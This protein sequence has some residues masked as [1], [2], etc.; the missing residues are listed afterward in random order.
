[1]ITYLVITLTGGIRALLCRYFRTGNVWLLIRGLIQLSVFKLLLFRIFLENET[2]GVSIFC[3]P[4]SDSCFDSRTFRWWRGTSRRTT[5]R[6]P[7]WTS[8][9]SS[10]LSRYWIFENRKLNNTLYN[11]QLFNYDKPDPWPPQKYLF[12]L[13]NL[14]AIFCNVLLSRSFSPTDALNN[15]KK[16]SSFIYAEVV[17]FEAV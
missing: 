4:C 9:T 12:V 14:I 15:G 2:F 7:R 6:S 13:F 16:T 11:T 1:M 10:R 17:T 3:L 5:R 8:W